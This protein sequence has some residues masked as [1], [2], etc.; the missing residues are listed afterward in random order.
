MQV[1]STT[2]VILQCSCF[3]FPYIL[4]FAQQ[5]PTEDFDGDNLLDFI[6]AMTLLAG[7]EDDEDDFSFYFT[8]D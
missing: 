7:D 5:C 8:E 3:T 4:R 2:I 6:I 1:G